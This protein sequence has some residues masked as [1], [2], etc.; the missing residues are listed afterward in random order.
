M[1]QHRGELQPGSLGFISRKSTSGSKAPAQLSD[2][3]TMLAEFCVEYLW[4]HL[5]ENVR[6]SS[7]IG[8]PDSPASQKESECGIRRLLRMRRIL[9]I[10]AVVKAIPYSDGQSVRMYVFLMFGST[11]LDP[12]GERIWLFGISLIGCRPA[13]VRCSFRDHD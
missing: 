4:I 6:R 1:I 11:V 9:R 5:S 2:S 8:V 3:S 12:E 13:A 10:S 7:Q